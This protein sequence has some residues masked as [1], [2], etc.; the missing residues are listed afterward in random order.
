MPVAYI[1]SIA[2]LVWVSAV[3]S[4]YF[5]ARR[6]ATKR[7]AS[8]AAAS[9]DR[10][11]PPGEPNQADAPPSVALADV[12]PVWPDL[13]LGIDHLELLPSFRRP[14][15]VGNR[16]P[17]SA[18]EFLPNSGLRVTCGSATVTVTFLE[19][20]P[21]GLGQQ[22]GNSGLGIIMDGTRQYINTLKNVADSYSETDPA[23][24]LR[25]LPEDIVK[26]ADIL[27]Y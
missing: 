20:S 8:L 14:L 27:T 1:A 16:D 5:I 22:M 9:F 15:L 6:V 21:K 13:D 10:G 19:E 7:D 4:I 26:P 25:H 2:M 17:R 12:L 23:V 11:Q 24:R 18:F 3:I